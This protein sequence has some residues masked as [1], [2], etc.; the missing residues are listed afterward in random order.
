MENI[1]LLKTLITKNEKLLSIALEANNEMRENA[2]DICKFMLL[3]EK[4]TNNLPK[5]LVMSYQNIARRINDVCADGVKLL[6]EYKAFKKDYMDVIKSKEL[7][8]HESY[9]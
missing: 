7:A 8:Y 2:R 4:N 9:Y 1:E 5:K 3:V 6:E